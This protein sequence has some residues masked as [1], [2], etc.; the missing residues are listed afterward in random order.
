MHPQFIY[1]P[2]EEYEP[3]RGRNNKSA[4]DNYDALREK[5]NDWVKEGY[6]EKLSTKPL[7]FNPMT[8]ASKFDPVTDK[9]KLCP[10]I[11]LSRCLN[12]HIDKAKI[13]L[14]GLSSC[15]RTLERFDFMTVF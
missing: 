6:V 10:C 15:Q 12:F 11:D 3:P 2:P 7:F 14:D 1:S 13:K 9:T 4:R 8:V 5:V